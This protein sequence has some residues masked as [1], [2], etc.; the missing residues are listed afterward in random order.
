[1]QNLGEDTKEINFEQFCTLLNETRNVNPSRFSSFLGRRHM[2]EA[3]T[4]FKQLED[5]GEVI[6]DDMDD[7]E[8]QEASKEVKA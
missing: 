3:V 2:S 4:F 1:M 8:P 6:L 5:E 7:D